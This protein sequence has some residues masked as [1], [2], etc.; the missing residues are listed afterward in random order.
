VEEASRHDSCLSTQALHLVRDVHP[1]AA[2]VRDLRDQD[3]SEASAAHSVPVGLL[4]WES[5][6]TLRHDVIRAGDLDDL[7]RAVIE[8]RR[9]LVAQRIAR[10]VT[11]K[12]SMFAPSPAVSA[13]VMV[14]DATYTWF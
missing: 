9:R 13:K 14:K 2:L 3:E 10:I 8:G 7:I 6:R 11:L 1:I 5:Q 4:E 12:K